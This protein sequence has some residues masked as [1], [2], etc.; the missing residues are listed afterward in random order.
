[1]E[2]FKFW[3]FS[4]MVFFAIFFIIALFLASGD[5]NLI[6]QAI[7]GSLPITTVVSAYI[8]YSQTELY[9]QRQEAKNKKKQAE[10]EKLKQIAKNGVK[11][12]ICG[13]TQIQLVKRGWNIA[14]GMLDSSNVDRMCI[15]C[16]HKW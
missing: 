9:E 16:K 13:S 5:D 10:I 6:K 3:F 14:T 7:I 4:T 1:M 12:P 8:A 11:C 15:N 2:K